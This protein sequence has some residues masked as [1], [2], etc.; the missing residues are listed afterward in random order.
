MTRALRRV[1]VIGAGLAGLA[2]ALAAASRGL[3][4][5]LLDDAPERPAVPAH[6]E[7]VPNMLRDLAEL[8]VAEDC[9][10]AGFAYRGVEVLDRQGRCLHELPTPH[11][12]GQRF[13]AALGIRHGDLHQV[14]ERAA[15]LRGVA[16]AREAR[17]ARV[18][19]HGEQPGVVLATGESFEADLVV[20][21][22]GLQGALRGEVFPHAPP[23]TDLGQ[24][25]W[26]TLMPRPVD[27][28]RPLI[29]VGDAGRRV[30][31]VPVRHDIA[32]L[33]LTEPRP[34]AMPP[35]Q[36]T[37]IDPIPHLRA[38][39]ASF[40]PRV[41]A[42]AVHLRD[43]LPVALRPVRTGLL[44]AP[45]YRAGVLAVGDCA[46]ALPPHL[47]QAAA[48]AIED[49]RV[50]GELMAQAPDRAALLDG[51]QRRRT[52]RVQRVHELTVTAARWDLAPDG[53]ADLGR[54]S[55]RL[56]RT[57]ALPA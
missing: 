56:A 10:R 29:A 51:F 21:A 47:G 1:C 37:P 54:L 30:V 7:V 26:H 38:V 31:M 23:V 49:A 19:G 41:R 44:D 43:G 45:W 24:A 6:I 46:H 34:G 9:V 25:W 52:E 32:G 40:A 20:L 22:T 57:V 12:A 33:A 14:L 11:L 42:A 18:Q 8:G 28:D 15:T 39:L 53:D 2:C 13:P 27:L 5:Q 3:R 50:L 36:V 4:V 48:Q 55:D 35:A 16:L 17:V